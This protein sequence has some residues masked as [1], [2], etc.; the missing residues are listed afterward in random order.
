MHDGPQP[1]QRRS[2]R[3]LLTAAIG[4]A[5][6][7][8]LATPALAGARTVVV[9]GAT[10]AI[11]ATGPAGPAGPRG[12]TGAT[13]A[14]GATG[15]GLQGLHGVTGATGVGTQGP[16]GATG[17]AVGPTLVPTIYAVPTGTNSGEFHAYC[18]TG[19]W[20]IAGGVGDLPAIWGP[21]PGFLEFNNGEP[22]RWNIMLMNM[23]IP[24]DQAETVTSYALC[25]EATPPT[26]T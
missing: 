23:L 4:T 14:T 7:G 16:T 13:G 2:R 24:T 19:M 15:V 12:V 11:G 8:A 17:V 9:Q 10:G 1:A 5:A 25:V 18:P 26:G 20:P 22:W 21:S 6:V 3:T